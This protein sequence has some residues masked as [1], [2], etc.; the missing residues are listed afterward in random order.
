MKCELLIKD[1]SYLEN[2]VKLPTELV[3][4]N[5]SSF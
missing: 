2:V 3:T 1:V 4:V 5:E